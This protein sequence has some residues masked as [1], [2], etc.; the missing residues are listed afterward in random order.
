M[1]I[2]IVIAVAVFR[3]FKNAEVVGFSGVEDQGVS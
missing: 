2:V 1:V 3:G